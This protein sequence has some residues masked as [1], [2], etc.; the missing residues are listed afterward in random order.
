MQAGTLAAFGCCLPLTGWT[1]PPSYYQANRERLLSE[2]AGVCGEV[3]QRLAPRTDKAG[4][5]AREAL[6]AFA[7]MIDA[8]PGIGGE[9]NRNQPY[10]VYA[11][12][13]AAISKAMKAH[14][15]AASDAGRLYYDLCLDSLRATPPAALKATGEAFFSPEGYAA[16]VAWAEWTHLRTYPGDWV[17]T[18]W[19]GDGRDYD[20]GLDYSECGAFKFFTSQ[21]EEEVAPYFCLNDFPRSSLQGTGLSRQNTLAQGGAVCDFRYKK[22]RP[23]AQSWDTEAP[24]LMRRLRS[25]E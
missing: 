7:P 4:A 16:T 18:V 21:G 23:V 13:L 1:S 12:W 11:G 25:T 10:I 15:M 9:A 22:G 19:R 17:A 20:I 24:K 8:M 5:V 14:G 3:G 2:F 6:E